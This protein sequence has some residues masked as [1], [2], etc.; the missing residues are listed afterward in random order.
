MVFMHNISPKRSIRGDI[1]FI[2]TGEYSTEIRGGTKSLFCESQVSLKSQ[3]K[4][5]VLNFQL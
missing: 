1:D 3:V 2:H 4:C 5:Q